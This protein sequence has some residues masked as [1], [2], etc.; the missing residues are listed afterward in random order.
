MT[1]DHIW[2][3]FMRKFPEI[4]HNRNPIIYGCELMR[5]LENWR[6]HLKE[7]E[8]QYV[9]ILEC[10]DMCASSS[11]MMIIECGDRTFIINVPQNGQPLTMAMYPEERNVLLS[12][13]TMTILHQDE[14]KDEVE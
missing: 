12:I 5:A 9:H 11:K 13:L 4:A 14:L 10:D 8:K 7:N 1:N 6:N 2:Q 3:D